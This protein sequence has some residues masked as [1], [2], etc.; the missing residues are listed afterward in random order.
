[1]VAERTQVRS[2]LPA[3]PLS[4]QPHSFSAQAMAQQVGYTPNAFATIAQLD[5]HEE[6]I[7]AENLALFLAIVGTARAFLPWG[8]QKAR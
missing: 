6:N 1:M 4:S 3:R 8:R 7:G 2:S 5:R